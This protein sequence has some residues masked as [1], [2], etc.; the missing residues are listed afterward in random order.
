M[1]NLLLD[2]RSSR[3]SRAARLVVL[4]AGLAGVIVI[5]GGPA[6]PSVARAAVPM[7]R[8][9]GMHPLPPH[10]GEYCYID[11]VH[12]HHFLPDDNRVYARLKNG[13]ELYVGDP[14]WLGYDGPKVGYFG[15]HPLAVPLA[16]EAEPL[17]CYIATAHYHAVAPAPSPNMVLKDGVYWYL[18]PPPPIDVQRSW[19]NE[20]H[21]VKGYTAPHLDLSA[22]PPGYHVFNLGAP[23]AAPPASVPAAAAPSVKT[24]GKSGAPGPAKPVGAAA[25]AR[26][27]APAKG[28][29]V[30]AGAAAPAAT[31]ATAA[32]GGRP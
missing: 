24:K 1:G 8:Y 14:A 10:Q 12:F 3:A 16:P 18:G 21:A 32:P 9:V 11:A 29:A 26:P 23:P 15:P 22:A 27:A 6:G 20:V 4:A 31:A 7:V 5:G 25:P 28:T 30:P 19:V 2:G 17:F 13:G